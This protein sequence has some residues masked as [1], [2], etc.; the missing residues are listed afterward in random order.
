MMSALSGWSR[1]M[2]DSKLSNLSALLDELKQAR[3]RQILLLCGS[4]QWGIAQYKAIISGNHALALSNDDQ[5]E[6]AIWPQHLHQILGQEFQFVC[7]D[8][9]SG[10]VPNK[11]TAAAGT[12]QA[13]GLLIL[14]VPE[15]DILKE[16]CDPALEKWLSEGETPS[17]SPFLV[18]FAKFIKQHSIWFISEQ[19]NNHLPKHYTAPANSLNLAPQS[20]SLASIIQWLSK[21]TAAPVL[22]SA[23]RGRGKSTVLGLIAAHYKKQNIVI[24]AQ[25]RRAVQ[26]SFKH[27]AI[28]L[29]IQEP[30]VQ[31]NSLHNLTYM[32]P[33]VLLASRPDIDILLIDEAAAIPVPMLKQLLTCCP[34]V[35]F[36]STLVGYE[37]NGRGY[38]LRFQSH[39]QKHYPHYLSLQLEEPIRYASNDPLER[40]LRVLF[41]LD[42]NYDA[43]STI[44]PAS[45]QYR[46]ISR[47][48]LLND[49]TLLRQVF[50]L[51]V[52]A[53]YQ[54]SVNDLRQL[55][56]SP[57]NRLFIATQA[58]LLIGVCLV[59]I[60]GNLDATLAAQI[61]LGT[62]R[63]A[64]HMMAQQLAQLQGD[65]DFITRKGARIV[66]I[67]VAPTA[68]QQGVGQAL[69]GFT[70]QQLREQVS[71]FG[72]SFGAQAKLLRFW[73]KLGFEAVKLGFKQDKSSGEFAVLVVHQDTPL[74]ISAIRTQFKSQ[75]FFDL[76]TLYQDLPW[77][78]VYELC[79]SLPSGELK[80]TTQSQLTYL[81]S[82]PA[83]QQQIAPFLY[84]AIMTQ[85]NILSALTNIS[86]MR[87][88][89]LLLQRHQPKELVSELKIESKKQLQL[90]FQQLLSEVY[91][92]ITTKKRPN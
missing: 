83:T 71:Y 49:E 24:C 34:K 18:R 30:S 88:I 92:E 77:Q 48:D 7:Y 27:L 74:N 11:I 89:L 2:Q 81:A 12:V 17:S 79:H 59:N 78:L 82:K 90:V 23:D 35:I 3:H 8:G 63:P 86:Q 9:Y 76:P 43:P 57:S 68:Q 41:A 58:E 72:S 16:W 91:A 60:E 44:Q 36:A 45:I 25:Q 37:G 20:N 75:L 80:T 61:T 31:Q 14:L 29:G 51:L 73:Q 6:R 28:E 19:S 32:P 10:I 52:L 33:D 64:G 1:L 47:A 46:S 85:P 50:A 55:L 13:G 84:D 54:T 53:H 39:L 66:R 26:N 5:F 21:K 87:L 62:R 67:A 15:L 22:L 70:M 38:T 42:S 56:D 69:I 65:T 40:Q 4:R